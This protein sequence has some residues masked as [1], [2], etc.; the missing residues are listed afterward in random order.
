[1][2]DVA[3]GVH[4]KLVR[5]HPHV[6]GDVN[7]TDTDT[8]LRNWDAIKREEK[9]RTSVFDGVASRSRR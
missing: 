6:F 1:M 5:R 2:A 4:D 8:V 3:R 9:R 7:A